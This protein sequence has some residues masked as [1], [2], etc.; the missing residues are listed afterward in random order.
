MQFFCSSFDFE[1]VIHL[2]GLIIETNFSNL[3]LGCVCVDCYQSP[4]WKLLH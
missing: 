3:S 1:A 4:S 2:L